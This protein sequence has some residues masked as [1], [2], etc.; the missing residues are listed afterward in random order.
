LVKTDRCADELRIN[1]RGAELAAVRAF[2]A[3]KAGACGF[4]E[5]AVYDIKV[6]AGEAIAN[7]IEHG[8]PKGESNTVTVS[9]ERGDAAFT[10]R[11]KDEGVFKRSIPNS[12]R[13]SD[14]RGHGILLML[15]LM[16]KVEIDESD[17]GT[18]VSLTKRYK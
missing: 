15:S 6:A 3:R 2:L 14:Y 18:T 1:S 8:S 16:D 11:V 7:A 13:A 9:C 5:A 12:G 17:R 4:D 10:I